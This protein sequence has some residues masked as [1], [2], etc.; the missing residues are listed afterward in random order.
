MTTISPRTCLFAAL[1]A[2]PALALGAEATAVQKAIRPMPAQVQHLG[3]AVKP[4]PVIVIEAESL[5]GNK[6]VSAGTVETQAMAGFGADWGGNAQ[7]FWR[8]PAPVDQPIRDWPNLRLYPKAVQAGRYKVALAHTVAPD[9]GSVRVFVKGQPVK[10][11]DGY[12]AGV[13]HRRLEL[14][15]FNL[16]AGAFELVFTVF[17]KNGAAS[18]YYVGLDRVELTPVQ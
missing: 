3:V 17:S 10:D 13:A 11:Y 15:E 6:I 2:L 9:Y 18:N 16:A 4:N 12:A 1:F 5:L 14:G 7:V 8:P